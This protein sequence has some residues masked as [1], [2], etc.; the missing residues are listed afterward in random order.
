MIINVSFEA[1]SSV[2]ET[3]EESIT[4]CKRMGVSVKYEFNGV[5]IVIHPHSS[6]KDVINDYF[7]E[8]ELKEM[9]RKESW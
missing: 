8:I 9:V 6:K 2:S 5:E 1:G 4:Y 3:I 7:T